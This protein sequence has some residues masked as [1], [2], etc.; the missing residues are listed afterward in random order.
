MI[1]D[2]GRVIDHSAQDHSTSE[3][4]SYGLFFSLVANDRNRFDRILHWTEINLA[5]GDL[6]QHLPVWLW[7][8]GPDGQWKAL[9]RNS[10]ADSDLWIAYSLI[11]AGR[12]WHEPRYSRLGLSLAA[13][14]ARQETAQ[15]PGLGTTLLPG[16]YGFHPDEQTW[17]LNPSYLPPFVLARLSTAAPSGPWGAVL[18]SLGP[19]LA[20]GSGAG[21]AMDWVVAGQGIHPSATPAQRAAGDAGAMP[22]G[23]FEAIRVY[24]WLG[25]ADPETRG[26][27]AALGHIPAMADY[28]AIHGAPPQLVDAQGKVVNQYAP[29]G[30]FAAAA[31]YLRAVGR[32]AEAKAQLG[33]A[34]HDARCGNGS[35]W[36][37]W[38]LLRS[39]SCPLRYGMGGGAFSSG[40][41]RDA[42]GEMEVNI[43]VFLVIGEP[44]NTRKN[45]Q[46]TV[47]RR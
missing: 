39:E 16:I 13:Q 6:S 20:Q 30:F 7:G 34:G 38:G 45:R 23:G 47:K 41:E 46:K 28:I 5:Q 18:D 9:D 40:S 29:A 31:P 26:V 25:I 44:V 22:I 36:K 1:D 42:A 19:M 24:L 32:E 14:V 43:A 37:E 8:R 33:S 10:A 35:L 27:K 4:Q 11:E 12:L 21:Y 17:V 3:G 15:V 2:Q